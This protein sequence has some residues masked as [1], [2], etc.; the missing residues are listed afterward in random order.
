MGCSSLSIGIVGAGTAGPAAAVY[1]ARAGHA[2]ELLERAPRNLPVG[3]GFLLQPTGMHVLEDLGLLNDLLPK[4]R[5]IRRLTCLDSRH[6]ALFDL[7]YGELSPRLFGAGTH[8]AALLGLLL[9]AAEQ[10]GTRVRWGREVVALERTST[11][12]P[13][14][15]DAKGD[16][17]GP[18]DLVLCCDG[19]QSALRAQAGIPVR[20]DRYPWGA[21]W[22]IGRRPEAFAPDTLWQRVGTTRELVGFLPTGTEADLLSFFWSIRLDQVAAWRSAP[23]ETWKREVV[24][25]VPQAAGLL[26]Q[27]K[28]HSQLAVAAYHDVRLPRWHAERVAILGDAGHALSPQLGQ[29][30]NLALMDAAELASA[31]SRHS[32]L[33]AAL[34]D[35]SA[36]RRRHLAFYQWSTRWLTPFFQSDHQALGRARD[37]LFPW[38]AK[39]PW[40]R[41]EM[42][43]TMAGLKTGLFAQL[44]P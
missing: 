37:L 33:A 34:A 4:T 1:L 24:R 17:H 16:E 27:V 8:R 21:L 9:A 19:A 41:R 43:K 6:H 11:G 29:G 14:L 30:V 31:L 36:R 10:A 20:V 44:P 39:I 22:F 7:H 28:D 12:R 38:F 18:Y 2:V 32:T 13:R 40:L 25:L 3:A 15:R 23:L 26:D 42:V 35:F 5:A